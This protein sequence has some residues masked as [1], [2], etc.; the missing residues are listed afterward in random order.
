MVT[1]LITRLSGQSPAVHWSAP[2]R[3]LSEPGRHRRRS[4]HPAGIG[5]SIAAARLSGSVRA[6]WQSSDRSLA[7][8]IAATLTS[9]RSSPGPWSSGRPSVGSI[10]VRIRGCRWRQSGRS[11]GRSPAGSIA[12]HGEAAASATVLGGR[13]AVIGRLHCGGLYE[14]RVY[15]ERVVI[16]PSHWPAPLQPRQDARRLVLLHRHPANHRPAPLQ[17]ADRRRPGAHVRVTRP[18]TSH[19]CGELSP[20]DHRL[21][22]L[23]P[24]RRRGQRDPPRGHPAL[25]L[26]AHPAGSIAALPTAQPVSRGC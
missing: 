22:P 5:R 13:P 21:A 18:I 23:R 1:R 3:R 14:D 10:A 7:G 8:S 25:H 24:R 6:P 2:L 15:A 12:S 11:S 9:C 4:T 26:S 16:R 19:S 17:R 20:S